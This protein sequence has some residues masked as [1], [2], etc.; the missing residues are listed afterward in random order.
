MQK[1]IEQ[2]EAKKALINQNSDAT[3]EE[4]DAADSKSYR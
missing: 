1:A 4:K 2:A 3:R